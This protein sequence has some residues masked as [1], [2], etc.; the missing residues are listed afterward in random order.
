MIWWF[1]FH[2][3]RKWQILLQ[4]KWHHT[5]LETVHCENHWEA[6]NWQVPITLT[7]NQ[8]PLS[9]TDSTNQTTKTNITNIVFGNTPWDRKQAEPRN[10][11]TWRFANWHRQHSTVPGSTTWNIMH[12]QVGYAVQTLQR[13]PGFE[14]ETCSYHPMWQRDCLLFMYSINQNSVL[15]RQSIQWNIIFFWDL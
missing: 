3:G 9:T 14:R 13:G 10:K 2:Q 5:Y 1:N 12:W 6:T 7:L 4:G 8:L 15:V 11:P